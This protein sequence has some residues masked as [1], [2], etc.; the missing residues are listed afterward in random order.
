VRNRKFKPEKPWNAPMSDA[1][2]IERMKARCVISETGC[3]LWQGT[4]GWK[5]YGQISY[6]NKQWGTHRLSYTLHK[7]PIPKGMLVCHTCDVRNC[8]NPEHLWVG[9]N[10][11]NMVDCSRKGRADDQWRTHC[12]HGHE[13]TPENTYPI[14]MTETV[15]RACKM[16]NRVRYRIRAG[17]PADLARTAPPVRKGY[18]YRGVPA[19]RMS[20]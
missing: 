16:C 7:G 6:R 12:I 1:D 20:R 10:K 8:V 17:W 3:W 19:K 13:F 14:R 4:L 5:G 9:T 18:T 11:Q 2:Y 15:K